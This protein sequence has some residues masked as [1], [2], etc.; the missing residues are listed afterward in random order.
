MSNTMHHEAASAPQPSSL[1]DDLN[2]ALG[3]HHTE[4]TVGNVLDAVSKKGFGLLLILLALP[5][6]L[7]VPAAGYSTPFGLMLCLLGGQML[8]GRRVP[9]LPGRARA[10]TLSPKL[11]QRLCAGGTRAARLL[12]RFVRPRIGALTGKTGQRAFA[13]III[14]MS[15]LMCLPIP[16]T[17]TFPAAVIFL[18]GIGLAER[19]GLVCLLSLLV[20]VLAVAVYVVPIYLLVS[21]IAEYGVA[22]GFEHLSEQ[23]SAFKDRLLGR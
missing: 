16:S 9:W 18:I 19:D 7:P 22:G 8:V 12:E 11:R 3:P 4:V 6:A 20:G 13:V 15:L 14:L 5:S 2:Q 23:M 21:Y 17:N 1:S 10:L